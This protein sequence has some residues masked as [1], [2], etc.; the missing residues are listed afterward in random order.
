MEEAR[1]LRKRLGGAMRQAGVLAA[2]GL[3]AL[4]E[5][6]KGLAEDHANAKYLEHRLAR[7]E[8]VRVRPVATNIVV[9]DLPAGFS[10]NEVS[11]ALKTRGVLINAVNSKFM[12]ALT[13]YDAG[14]DDCCQAM[15]ALEEV[16]AAGA[17]YASSAGHA[18]VKSY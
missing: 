7:I 6:P 10:P 12:R 15:D 8:G 14:R 9:F 16:L 13:H 18:A 17:G 2:A 11:A 4:E 5:S 3:V 1:Y